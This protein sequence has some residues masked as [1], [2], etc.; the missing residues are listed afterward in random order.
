MASKLIS[1]L[2]HSRTQAHVYHWRTRSFAAH[3]ALQAYYES[4]V[5]L[6]DE[7]AEGYQGRYGMISGYTSAPL[8]QN[9]MKARAYFQKLLKTI[10]ATKVRDTY[11][12]NIL[13]T[14][15]QLVYQTMYLLTLDQQQ[16][17]PFK[18]KPRASSK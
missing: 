16:Q 10:D 9:P 13:D 5:P 18:K 12:K 7:Y 14:I 4:I 2:L 6:F 8:N 17:R 1:S 15:R 3:R 11:L